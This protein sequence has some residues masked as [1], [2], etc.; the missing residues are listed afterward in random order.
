MKLREQRPLAAGGSRNIFRILPCPPLQ[1]AV[2][3]VCPSL[4]R[5][6]NSQIMLLVKPSSS[7][8]LCLNLGTKRHVGLCAQLGVSKNKALLDPSTP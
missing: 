3:Y 6:F 1:A 7:S 5:Y 2:V 4:G 8:L